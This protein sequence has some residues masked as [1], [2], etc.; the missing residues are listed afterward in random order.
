M[1]ARNQSVVGGLRWLFTTLLLL[2]HLAVGFHWVEHSLSR[3]KAAIDLAE[4]QAPDG[5][6]DEAECAICHLAA[7]PQ[8]VPI[9]V[10]A[11]VSF[12]TTLH[13]FNASSADIVM[14]AASPGFHSRAPPQSLLHKAI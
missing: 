4:A 1:K 11:T 10:T 12:G 14:V 13:R 2:S 7:S 6:T 3:E 9:A 5:D 8:I